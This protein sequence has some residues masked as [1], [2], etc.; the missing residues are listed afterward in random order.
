MPLKEPPELTFQKHIAAF[1]VRVHK[2][3]VLDQSDITDTEH[4]IAEDQLWAFLKA[5]QSDTLKKLT[6][7][8]G[9][10]ARDEVFKALRKELEHTPLWLL[11]RQRLKVRGLEFHLYYPKPRFAESAAAGKYGENAGA[12]GPE[13]QPR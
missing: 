6:D 4:V 2:Y 9:T 5:T 3:G 7:D 13:S 1:L 10:D 11:F 8:Y 12:A